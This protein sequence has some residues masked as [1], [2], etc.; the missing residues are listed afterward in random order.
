MVM[1]LVLTISASGELELP[2]LEDGE[3][4]EPPRLPAVAPVWPPADEAEEDP[5]VEDARALEVDPA[6]TGSPG[7]RLAR[8][9]IVPLMGA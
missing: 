4:L 2:E 3:E 8:E 5:V 9:T 1:L 7:K 6:E